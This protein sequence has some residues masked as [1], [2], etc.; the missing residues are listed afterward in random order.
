VALVVGSAMV[1]VLG[2]CGDDDDGASTGDGAGLSALLA[3]IPAGDG[4]YVQVANWRA[5]RE[6]AGVDQPGTDADGDD[7]IDYI[8]ALEEVGLQAASP[9]ELAGRATALRDELGFSVVDLDASAAV[10]EP[11]DV[12]VV[13]A[14]RIDDGAV[15]DTVEDDPV[16]ADRLETG[17]I[18]G[19]E[20]WSWGDEDEIDIRNRS[21]LRTVG[22]SLRLAVVDDG[23]VLTR[24]T[25]TL[26]DLLAVAAGDARSLA[27]D[28]DLAAVA[29]ALDER[30]AIAAVLSDEALSADPV[31]VLDTRVPRPEV[32]DGAPALPS[33]RAYGSGVAAG[34]GGPTLVLVLAYGD[35]DRAQEAAA[36]L[37]ARFDDGTSFATRQPWAELVRDAEVVTD[38]RLVVATGSIERPNLWL[39]I[40]LQRDALLAVS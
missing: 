39:Q 14:G 16:F 20:Y 19:V 22:E 11:P 9:Y 34:D 37:Q 13:F 29:G 10:G 8:R 15:R 3:R 35:D 30:G 21:E 5:A 6:A 28:E 31:R 38:G 33:Y 27:D 36:A 12:A 26:E 25:D 4:G 7:V 32:D 17:E 24:R 1:G 18:D 40:V 23:A 2:A